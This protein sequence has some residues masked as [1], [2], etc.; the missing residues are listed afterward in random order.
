MIDWESAAKAIDDKADWLVRAAQNTERVARN[1]TD[2]GADLASAVAAYIADPGGVGTDSLDVSY[3]RFM[4]RHS[5]GFTDT[6]M[7]A[8]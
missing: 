3:Q 6:C 8:P 4:G 1:A 7:V 2:A 5:A